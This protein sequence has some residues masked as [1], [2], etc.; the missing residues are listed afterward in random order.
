LR[1]DEG[2]DG[3]LADIVGGI[4]PGTIKKGEEVE[5]LMEQMLR[6]LAVRHIPTGVG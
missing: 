2:A 3:S 6:E 1:A 5:P 4:Q